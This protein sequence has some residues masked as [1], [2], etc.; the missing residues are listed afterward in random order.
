MAIKG[1]SLSD[2]A[3]QFLVGLIRNLAK[4]SDGIDDIN[5][6][7]DGV[8]S[9]VHVKKLIDKCLEDANTHAEA[10][11]SNLNKLSSKKTTV[12]PTLDNSEFNVIYLY[13]AN[14]N[15]PFEQFLKIGSNEQDAELIDMGNTN[16]SLDNYLTILEASKTYAKKVDLDATNAEVNKLKTKV[17]TDTLTTTASDLCGGINELK[18]ELGLK[19]NDSE[20][21]KKTDVVTTIDN[22]SSDSQ[23]ASAKAVYDSCIK[24]NNI[25][26][27]TTLAQLGLE[28]GCKTYDIFSAMPDNSYCEIACNE[29][30][31][32][33][34]V[35][36]IDTPV[37]YGLLTI[38]KYDKTR[39]SIELKMSGGGTLAPNEMYIGNLKGNDGT[40]LSWKRVCTTSVPDVPLTKVNYDTSVVKSGT[41]QYEVLN[42]VCY[43]HATG[44]T[45][46]KVGAGQMVCTQLL[47]QPKTIVVTS[48]MN[49]DMSDEKIGLFYIDSN[50]QNVL[51][52][53]VFSITKTGWCDFSYPVA[54]S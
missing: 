37:V 27:Y 16:I 45:F 36:V 47:P 18:T 43:V 2:E 15:A 34:L 48:P 21:V 3:L 39:F 49:H 10:I 35:N 44:V 28:S 32:G 31:S 52:S 29:S 50:K 22:S 17:G 20:V 23:V 12:Q 14:G 51:R 40:S 25:K 24:D 26:T 7:T 8:Y 41:I 9:S 13:S 33:V 38:R 46:A 19:A 1:T 4:V 11:I 42:G 5:L 30:K 6:R 54:E 53:H